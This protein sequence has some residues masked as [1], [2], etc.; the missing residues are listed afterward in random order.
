MR[1]RG[2]QAP[3][4]D[5]FKRHHGSVTK[6]ASK[7]TTTEKVLVAST[8]V[9]STCCMLLLSSKNNST[10]YFASLFKAWVIFK[11][12]LKKQLFYFSDISIS[13]R[14]RTRTH[15]HTHMH[16][17]PH[18]RMPARDNESRRKRASQAGNASRYACFTSGGILLHGEGGNNGS[19]VRDLL[20][21]SVWVV[22]GAPVYFTCYRRCTRRKDVVQLFLGA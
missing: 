7:S 6:Q 8:A 11:K 5:D 12:I 20:P 9:R 16:A 19:V 13:T 21:P 22:F 10:F 17:Q 14:A 18:N 15:S 2:R 1:K 3:A 4:A